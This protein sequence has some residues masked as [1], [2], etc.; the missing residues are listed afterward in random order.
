[1]AGYSSNP[2]VIKLGIK[3]NQKL[4]LINIP[5]HYGE[6]IGDWPENISVNTMEDAY[7]IDFIHFF[8]QEMA[9]LEVTF[10]K[11]K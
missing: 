6:L 2:L 8:T 5:D 4:L 3:A 10:P 1:M 11:L 7:D 9:E